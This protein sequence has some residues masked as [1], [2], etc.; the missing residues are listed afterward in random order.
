I[1]EALKN[2]LTP[3]RITFNAG[4]ESD[5]LS[6]SVAGLFKRPRYGDTLKVWIGTD[7][8]EAV[9]FGKFV[10]QTS[11]RVDNNMLSIT[12]SSANFKS[13]KT[14]RDEAYE[15]QTLSA[16]AATIA[17]R[18][19][20]ALKSD[21]DAAIEYI[22]QSNE[23]DAAFLKRLADTYDALFSVK[24]GTLV[25]RKK[26]KGDLP[27]YEVSAKNCKSLRVKY[28][29]RTEYMS[30]IIVKHDTQTNEQ[31]EFTLGEGEPAL[32]I[33]RDFADETEAIAKAAAALQKANRGIVSGSL[34]I[35]HQ[36]IFAGGVLRLRETIG[37]D[38]DYTIT[39]AQHTLD[40]YETTIDFER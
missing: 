2:N 6:L 13:L 19:D 8:K 21:L 33:K 15:K 32:R 4:D 27:I 20:L 10:V 31:V 38:G 40:N 29:D 1:T 14:K 39:K 11:E 3:L 5:E 24:N 22:A 30:A 37:D 9:Y 26:D 18:N 28:S 12:A 35:V 16:I 25:F 34:S 17:T 23:S 7:G 36:P